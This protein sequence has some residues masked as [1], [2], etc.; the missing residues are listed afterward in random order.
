MDGHQSQRAT[1]PKFSLALTL[2]GPWKGVC[3]SV[4]VCV[5]GGGGMEAWRKLSARADFNLR[6]LPCYL[7]SACE[8]LI[9]ILNFIGEQDSV[10]RFVKGIICCHG[11]LISEAIFSQILN[12]LTYCFI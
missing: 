6:E 2:S 5:G 7:S 8:I 9:L 10:K 4:C 3:V 1:L 11:N 12:F